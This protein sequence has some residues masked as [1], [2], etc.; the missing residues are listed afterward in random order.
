[1]PAKHPNPQVT[2]AS[3]HN[4][5]DGC[6]SC[7][8]LFQGSCHLISPEKCMRLCFFTSKA[9]TATS[10]GNT[11]PKLASAMGHCRSAVLPAPLSALVWY[12]PSLSFRS[13]RNS[14]CAY[15]RAAGPKDQRRCGS[16]LAGQTK[17]SNYSTLV[18]INT[19]CTCEASAHLASHERCS[20]ANW[21]GTLHD[22][23]S[24]L[25]GPTFA[26][27]PVIS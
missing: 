14:R 10:S 9:F 26:L 24:L 22:S 6:K 23:M 18:Y 16:N 7:L 12:E 5:P 4:G 21:F 1:M 8:S 20:S 3:R 13:S 27:S 15:L 19:S 2:S 25:N 11:L 17:L